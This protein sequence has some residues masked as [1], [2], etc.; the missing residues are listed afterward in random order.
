ME[1]EQEEEGCELKGCDLVGVL[2]SNPC[3]IVFIFFSDGIHL[4]P[5]RERPLLVPHASS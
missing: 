1:E 4:N 2:S 5:L 3:E